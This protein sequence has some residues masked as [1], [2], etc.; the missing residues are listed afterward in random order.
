MITEKEYLEAKK[1]VSAYKKQLNKSIVSRW[2]CRHKKKYPQYSKWYCPDC[3]RLIGK[4]TI[5][6][7][8]YK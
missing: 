3:E 7:S 6:H 5:V 1:I 4:V 8:Q 2:F